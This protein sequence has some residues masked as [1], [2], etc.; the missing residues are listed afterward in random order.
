M[1]D[2]IDNRRSFFRDMAKKYPHNFHQLL[3]DLQTQ[4]ISLP[5]SEYGILAEAAWRLLEAEAEE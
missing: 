5:N 1:S 2:D 4:A 3:E